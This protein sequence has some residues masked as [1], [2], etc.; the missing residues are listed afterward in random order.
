MSVCDR[1][2]IPFPCKVV[3][4]LFASYSLF[5]SLGEVWR[6]LTIFLA[7]MG[8]ANSRGRAYLKKGAD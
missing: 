7:L 6:A 8:G 1:S 3:L 4:A 5:F 2:Q